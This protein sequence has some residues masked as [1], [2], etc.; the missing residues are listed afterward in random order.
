MLVY[1]ESKYSLMAVLMSATC[2]SSTEMPESACSAS[3]IVPS[4]SDAQPN[5][6]NVVPTQPR[7]ANRNHDD[8]ISFFY[9]FYF[10]ARLTAGHVPLPWQFA[11]STSWPWEADS[12][13][14]LIHTTSES[15]RP[16][17]ARMMN[18]ANS[19]GLQD[20]LDGPPNSYRCFS[21]LSSRIL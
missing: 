17:L 7:Q 4:T 14:R 3:A 9:P 8:D 11:S 5:A 19:C 12:L 16:E 20:N 6:H 13:A 18:A 1:F 21:I 2:P 10:H 15:T